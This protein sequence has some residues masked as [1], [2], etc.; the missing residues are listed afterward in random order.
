MGGG[1]DKVEYAWAL[2]V[3]TNM[4]FSNKIYGGFA[5]SNN[6]EA[7]NVSKKIEKFSDN[8][9]KRLSNTEIFNRDAIDLI[10]MKDTKTTFFYFDP[11][12]FESNC[13]HYEKLKEV[14]HR[15][16]ELLPTLKGKFLMSS[17]PSDQLTEIRA[18]N[19]FN[20]KDIKQNLSV[21]GKHNAGKVKTECLTWNYNLHGQSYELF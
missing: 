10:K 3:Q 20:F 7:R 16:L 5:F 4:S 8:L 13:G 12:Y 15:L 11:P 14:Y 2:W 1:K 21:S 18:L 6:G 19:G 17:Y 9:Y